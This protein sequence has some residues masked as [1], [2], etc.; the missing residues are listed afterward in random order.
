MDIKTSNTADLLYLNENVMFFHRNCQNLKKCQNKFDNSENNGELWMMMIWKKM[1][2][3]GPLVPRYEA[4]NC[5]IMSFSEMFL[6]CLVKSDE[7]VKDANN[8]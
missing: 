7:V 2:K 4:Q 6:S 3:V 1:L 8:Y 5:K